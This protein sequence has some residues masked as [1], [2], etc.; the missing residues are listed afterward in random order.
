MNRRNM[1]KYL[2]SSFTALLSGHLSAFSS[3]ARI[4]VRRS[5]DRGQAE[6]GWLSS[7]HSFSFASYR[8]PKYMGFRNLRVINQDI[9]KP[10]QGFPSHGHRD[11]EII[12]YVIDGRLKHE[13]S[14]GNVAYI[15][16][17]DIQRMTAGSGILHSEYNA[18]RSR[19][20]HFLQI[21]L[22]PSKRNLTPGYDQKFVKDEDK[23][24]K[25]SLL[26]GV[27]EGA[28]KLNSNAYLYSSHLE[29]GKKCSLKSKISDNFWIQVISG[30]VEV[31]KRRL[32]SGDGAS[33]ERTKLLDIQSIKDAHFIVFDLA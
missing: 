6:H 23:K 28:I 26:A 8:D 29:K 7:K 20:V 22:Q 21:W 11:M 10:S 15:Q 1:I 32:T 9:V 5:Q 18:S 24:N 12:S 16:P 14:R 2:T 27:N 13:D 17:G 30:E 31:L 3:K 33:I 4:R 19:D 25:L